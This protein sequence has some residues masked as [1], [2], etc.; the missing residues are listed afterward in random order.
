MMRNN[1]ILSSSLWFL[2]LVLG[3]YFLV[4]L[5][6]TT[7][8]K[9]LEESNL[10]LKDASFQVHKSLVE[11]YLEDLSPLSDARDIYLFSKIDTAFFFA[12]SLYKTD[13]MN[14]KTLHNRFPKYYSTVS[15]KEWLNW[16][17]EKKKES[18]IEEEVIFIYEKKPV[19]NYQSKKES[20]QKLHKLWLYQ[21]YIEIWKKTLFRI[22][23][24][25]ILFDKFSV[26]DIDLKGSKL[27]LI[28][29]ENIKTSEH[30]FIKSGKN[31]FSNQ[32][33][34]TIFYPKFDA[35]AT[36]YKGENKSYFKIEIK[37]GQ[38]YNFE[39][40]ELENEK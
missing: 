1:L 18:F 32:K 34:T 9:A 3:G 21:S 5:F 23:Y 39:I 36:D 38:K 12:D 30:L 7:K 35:F 15:E 29:S 17:P 8:I 27:A 28:Y 13:K 31:R 10:F 25:E 16:T 6:K 19:L 14:W 26:A 33:D 22:G 11:Q 24:Q 20:I 40:T 2:I 37:K 4:S